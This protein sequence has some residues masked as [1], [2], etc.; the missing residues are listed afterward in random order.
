MNRDADFRTEAGER[1]VDRVIDNLVNEMMQ[2][3]RPRGADV[4]RRALANRLEALEDLD[5]ISAV[6]AIAAVGRI[7]FYF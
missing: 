2:P 6:V 5:A 7:L 3:G 4:H 1:F